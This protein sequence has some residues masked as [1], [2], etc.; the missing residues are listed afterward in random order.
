MIF[1]IS[2]DYLQCNVL[3]FTKLGLLEITRKKGQKALK[4]IFTEN[5]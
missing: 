1:F 2:N 3:D 5:I 4:D